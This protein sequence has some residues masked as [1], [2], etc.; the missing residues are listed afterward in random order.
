MGYEPFAMREVLVGGKEIVLQIELRESTVEIEAIA[1]EAVSN[2][3]RPLNDMAAVSA[4]QLS[5]EEASRYAG[6]FD[7]PARLV[8]SFAGVA[9]GLQ[10]NGIVVRG[11]APKGLQWKLE[12]VDISNPSHF[13]D[14]TVLG[15]GGITALSSHVLDRSDFLTGAFPAEYGNA[16]SGVFDIRMRTGNNERYEHTFQIGGLGTEISSEGPIVNSSS[17][18][19]FNYRYAT[20]ALFAP[21]LPDDAGRIRYQDLSFKLN[22][23]TGHAG[24]MALWGLGATDR[25]GTEAG[26]DSNAWRYNQ[27]REDANNRQQT[28]ALGMTHRWLAGDRTFVQTILA[29]SGNSIGYR[30][31]RLSG[32]LQFYP[33]DHI[34][35]DTWKFTAASTLQ[36]KWSAAWTMRAGWIVERLHY[37]IR[38]RH[39]PGAVEPLITVV[40]EKGNGHLLRG[41]VQAQW[42]V[43]KT[44]QLNAG[45][46]IQYFSI[47]RRSTAE[48]RASLRWK[49][50]EWQAVSFGY[51]RHSQIERISFYLAQFEG[52]QPNRKLDFSKADHVVL[53]YDRSVSDHVRWKVEAFAQR[54]FDVP[55]IPDSSYSMLNLQDDWYVNH[56]MANRGRGRNMGVDLTLE[57]FLS[58][59]FYYLLT[60]SVFDSKYRGG[61]DVERSSRYNKN[62]VVNLLAGREWVIDGKSKRKLFGL[63]GRLTAMGGD[64]LTPVYYDPLTEEVKED[65]TRAFSE[66]KP[67]GVYA[68][69]TASYKILSGR[70]TH[71]FTLQ[72]NNVFARKEFY[73]YRYNLRKDRIDKE[74]EIVMVP[75]VSYKIEF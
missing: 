56:P 21:V 17:S 45:V 32:D 49:I 30:M 46:H 63:N 74:K 60:A 19:L 25:G 14:I 23:P 43:S 50:D 9:G 24:T 48:P 15:G 26:N 39:A 57:R 51:G 16:L 64:R 54:L 36:H 37:S 5:V 33:Q 55:V 18:Y 69:I 59:G 1:I 4:R 58:D 11:N 34:Q 7:D 70:L 13:A 47:N 41:F 6:G 67:A 20:L 61:D 75:N 68:D 73:G 52:V 66:R 22:F 10:N 31:K 28:G 12:D 40:D 65:G 8:S 3:D 27:D 38:L 2:K 35:D 62:Y 44:L 72:A 29:A 53:G 71:T 42:D